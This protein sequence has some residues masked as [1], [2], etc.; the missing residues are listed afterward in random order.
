MH[1]GLTPRRSP[2]IRRAARL[3]HRPCRIQHL[4]LTRWNGLGYAMQVHGREEVMDDSYPGSWTSPSVA[5]EELFGLAETD[6]SAPYK[7]PHH[8]REFADKLFAYEALQ[9]AVAPARFE[10]EP[11]PF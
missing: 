10:P 6:A 7:G 2:N 1:V 11:E 9:P 8:P 5:V 4:P 3:D